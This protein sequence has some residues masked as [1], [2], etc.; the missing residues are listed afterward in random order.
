[1]P[2]LILAAAMKIALIFITAAF[3]ATLLHLALW[4]KPR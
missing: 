2:A 1:M 4:R 3:L